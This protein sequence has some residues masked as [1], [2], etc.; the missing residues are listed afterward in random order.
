MGSNDQERVT[1]FF[2]RV[3]LP[4]TLEQISLSRQHHSELE[5]LVE[6]ALTRPP[7]WNMPMEMNHKVVREAILN[8][9]RLG[10]VI[11][12]EVGDEAYKRLRK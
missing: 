9:D 6:T 12:R 11:A 10:A 2:A 4:I 7:A 8:A 1:R 3:G 5:I